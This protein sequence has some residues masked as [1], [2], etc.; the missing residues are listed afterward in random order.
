[1]IPM[2]EGEWELFF[3]RGKGVGARLGFALMPLLFRICTKIA[4]A[5]KDLQTSSFN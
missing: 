5:D 1:M 3:I 2:I 4:H